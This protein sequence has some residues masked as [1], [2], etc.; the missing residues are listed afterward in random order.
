MLERAEQTHHA[1]DDDDDP[2]RHQADERQI[3]LER[4]G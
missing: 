2:A 4:L 1:K 3:P